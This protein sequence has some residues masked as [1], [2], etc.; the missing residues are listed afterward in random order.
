M[1]GRRPAPRAGR[2]GAAKPPPESILLRPHGLADLGQPPCGGAFPL[3]V[4]LG[5]RSAFGRFRV[6]V[7]GALRRRVAR[8][9]LVP[10]GIE[11]GHA[12]VVVAGVA[13]SS[14]MRLRYCGGDRNRQRL[15]SPLGVKSSAQTIGEDSSLHATFS[16]LWPGPALTINRPPPRLL[17]SSCSIR[18]IP[19]A[20]EQARR[21]TSCPSRRDVIS[22]LCHNHL[23]YL[24]RVLL[25]NKLVLKA[26]SKMARIA[27]QMS[28]GKHGSG[29]ARGKGD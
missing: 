13:D 23:G 27:R 15:L 1:A 26:R 20:A 21:A 9:D 11:G 8:L 28:G 2:A 16:M 22:C 24:S 19:C 18:Q 14:G 25:T 4:L 17:N 7:G 10:D 3:V 12:G 5:D 29:S 6:E